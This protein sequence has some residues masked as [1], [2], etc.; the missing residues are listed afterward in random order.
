MWIKLEDDLG[1][2]SLVNTDNIQEFTEDN[3][4]KSR[5]QA[6][7]VSQRGCGISYKDYP[8]SL[9]DIS[10]IMRSTLL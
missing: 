10:E 1:R 3:G 9:D 4:K 5:V 2:S 7:F 6:E 8:Y